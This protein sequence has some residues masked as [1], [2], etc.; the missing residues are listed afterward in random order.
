MDYIKNIV[1]LLALV[2][3]IM[4]ASRCEAGEH[5]LTASLATTHFNKSMSDFEDYNNNNRLVGYEYKF[6]SGYFVTAN[7][8]TNSYNKRS[9]SLFIGDELSFGWYGFR[10]AVGLATG[11][12][13]YFYYDK[14]TSSNELAVKYSEDGYAIKK[15]SNRWVITDEVTVE[16]NLIGNIGGFVTVSAFVQVESLRLELVFMA[17]AAAMLT[18]TYCFN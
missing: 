5:R 1:A 13:K 17:H 9:Y 11:Y 16:N 3:S 2:L 15:E 18:T 4:A 14:I 8:F 12:N 10:S 6:D 7:T